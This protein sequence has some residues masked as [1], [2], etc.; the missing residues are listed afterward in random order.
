LLV[1]NRGAWGIVALAVVLGTLGSIY[2][3]TGGV[4]NFFLSDAPPWLL[5]WGG[6]TVV[7]VYALWGVVAVIGHVQNPPSR[8]VWGPTPDEPTAEDVTRT[9][10]YWEATR[11]MARTDEDSMAPLIPFARPSREDGAA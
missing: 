9:N 8:L 4:G 11:P 1:N 5:Y 3:K 7:V 10:A 2:A 6:G